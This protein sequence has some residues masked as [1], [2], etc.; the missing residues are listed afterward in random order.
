VAFVSRADASVPDEVVAAVVERLA[1]DPPAALVERVADRVMERMAP[2]LQRIAVELHRKASLDQYL[3]AEEAARLLRS[4]RQRIYD[5]RS[6]GRLS[7]GGN[8]FAV[9]VRRSELEAFIA[10]GGDEGTSS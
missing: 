4:D 7:K 5:L 10:S 8:G 3:T 2:S 1:A 6:R 9:L